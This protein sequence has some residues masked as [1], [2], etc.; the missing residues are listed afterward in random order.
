MTMPVDEK[1]YCLTDS[2]IHHQKIGDAF[3][4]DENFDQALK[5]YF[6]SLERNPFNLFLISKIIDIS[7]KHNYLNSTSPLI[8]DALSKALKV[9][10]EVTSVYDMDS[11]VS[12]LNKKIMAAQGGIKNSILNNIKNNVKSSKLLRIVLLTCVWQR[13][14]LTEIFLNYYKGIAKKLE[15]E[16]ELILMAVGSEG[17]SSRKLCEKYGFYYLEYKNLPLSDKWEFGLKNSREFDPDA[18][19]IVGSDDFLS[20]SL[21]RCYANFLNEGYLF[22]GISDACF[23]DLANSEKILYWKGYGGLNRDRGM[24]WRLNETLGMGRMYS[25]LLLKHMDYSLWHGIHINKGLDGVAKDRLLKL[26]M[27]PV[28]KEYAIL[29]STENKNILFGQVA[30]RMKELNAIAL[31]VKSPGANVTNMIGYHR[32]KDSYEIIDESWDYLKKFFPSDTVDS[33]RDLSI[34]YG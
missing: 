11:S 25:G 22:V 3:Y 27:L 24:P 23:L 8:L 31:D 1:K 16:I 4:L 20:F 6:L 32:A 26:G 14:A 33:L 18:V 10:G 2:Y 7:R 19:I 9:R 34:S 28:L 21:F 17:D 12:Y 5:H 13:P 30:M 15:G 29:I